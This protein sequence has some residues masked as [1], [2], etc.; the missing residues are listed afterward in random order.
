M[1]E[2]KITAKQIEKL[3]NGLQTV[4]AQVLTDR[5]ADGKPYPYKVSIDFKDNGKYYSLNIETDPIEDEQGGTWD[6]NL[7]ITLAEIPEA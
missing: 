1:S 7:K 2:K 5:T 4:G 6:D 3:F